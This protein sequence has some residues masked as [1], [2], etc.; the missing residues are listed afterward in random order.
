MTWGSVVEVV[1]SHRCIE[2]VRYGRCNCRTGK[3][4]KAYNPCQR[5][6]ELMGE[7]ERLSSGDGDAAT[8]LRFLHRKTCGLSRHG[9]GCNHRGC[10]AKEQAM[11]FICEATRKAAG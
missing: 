11:D 8:L 1:G 4:L 5:A 7:A 2:R 10:I 3:G 9:R 6:E